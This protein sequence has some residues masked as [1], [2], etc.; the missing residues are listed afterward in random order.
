MRDPLADQSEAIRN[1]RRSMGPNASAACM[2]AGT[3]RRVAEPAFG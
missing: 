3:H 2:P 1:S